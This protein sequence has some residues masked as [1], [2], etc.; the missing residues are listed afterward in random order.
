[1]FKVL[2]QLTA[3]RS[4]LIAQIGLESWKAGKLGGDEAIRMKGQQI[5]QLPSFLASW[6]PSLYLRAI[7]EN[8]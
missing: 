4:Q 2:N 1:V 3:L 8:T 7:L 5:I 6:L